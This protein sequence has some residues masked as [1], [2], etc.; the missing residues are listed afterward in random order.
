[1]TFDVSEGVV[2][3]L[4]KMGGKTIKGKYIHTTFSVREPDSKVVE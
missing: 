3:P 1:M 4:S 2:C